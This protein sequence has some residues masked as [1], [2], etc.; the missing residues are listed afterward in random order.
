[1]MATA[2]GI[3]TLALIVAPFAQ[4]T[5]TADDPAT[6]P[7]IV[8]QLTELEVEGAELIE[9]A[10]PARYTVQFLPDGD[11]AIKADCNQV[12]GTYEVRGEAMTIELGAA[13]LVLCPPDSHDG[14]F[15]SVLAGANHHGFDDEGML[16][17]SGNEGS[18][19][20]TPALTG[21]LWEWQDFRGGNDEVI[22]PDH[23]ERY[24][25]TFLPDGKLAIQADC[26]RAIGRYTVE[27]PQLDLEVAGVTR[28]LC[29]E[30]SLMDRFVRDLD[31]ASSHVFS[32]GML[33]IALPLDSGISSFVARY[34]EP[35]AA[36]P[37]AG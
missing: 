37:A 35:T 13:T 25:V 16:L 24:T 26:D 11:L 9:I 7:P 1:M 6:I 23:P 32:D 8:W 28:M 27:G 20:L 10:E 34:V 19:R 3:F 2:L 14:A 12:T 31:E 17:L 33:H 15:T 5:P 30:G 18:L 22:A 4:A 36:T 29:P 21:V